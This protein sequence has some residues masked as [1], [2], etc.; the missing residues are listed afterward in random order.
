LFRKRRSRLNGG[1]GTMLGLPAHLIGLAGTA[2]VFASIA[3]D[4]LDRSAPVFE[5]GVSSGKGDR[6]PL[7]AS[8]REPI[9]VFTLELG[10]TAPSAIVLRSRSGDVLYKSDPM[11]GTTSMARDADLPVLN[12]RDEGPVVQ[13]PARPQPIERPRASDPKL[14][15]P[16]CE[17]VVSP[18]TRIDSSLPG[19]CLASLDRYRS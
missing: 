11:S 16:G 17:G 5:A 10:E 6:L 7:S 13:K 18:L 8:R 4:H 3:P 2:L 19:L 14:R 1:K 12:P 9:P 15:P